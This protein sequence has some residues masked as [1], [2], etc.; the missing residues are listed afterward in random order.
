M[1]AIPELVDSVDYP[2][3]RQLNCEMGEI[4]ATLQRKYSQI[5]Y[6]YPCLQQW[7]AFFAFQFQGNCSDPVH[8]FFN[9]FEFHLQGKGSYHGLA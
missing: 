1:V 2:S 3:K 7:S 9:F 8:F 6:I 5:N 4:Y